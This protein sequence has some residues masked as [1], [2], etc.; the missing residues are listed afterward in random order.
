MDYLTKPVSPPIVLARVRNHL[1]LRA[2]EVFLREQN[3][4]LQAARV[5]ADAASLAKTTFLSSMSHE[6]RS[7]LNAILGFA[8]LLET[9]APPP[10]PE[11]RESITQILKAG[12]HL[13]ALINEILDLAKVESGQVPLSLERVV[14]ATNCVGSARSQPI[15]RMA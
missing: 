4:E 12:W 1:A 11:Q 8:Q 14:M 6:L 3:V 5:A 10:T 13:L 9:D 7:P 2:M 15:V